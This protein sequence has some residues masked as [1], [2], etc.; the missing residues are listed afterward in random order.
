[1]TAPQSTDAPSSL[2]GR[3][4]QPAAYP[5]LDRTPF[6]AETLEL[7]RCVRDHD[8][9]TLSGLC[10]DDFGIVDLDTDGSA[11]LV[12]D[13]AAWE[14]W[15]QDLFGRLSTLGARTDT[16]VDALDGLVSGDLGYGVC[17]F[18]Q[19]LEAGGHVASFRCITTIV[20]KRVDG[21][22]VESRWHASLLEA[23]V[24]DALAAAG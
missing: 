13:R 14:E 1:M 8:L 5:E 23:D 3:R 24:P 9:A 7:F 11:R 18:T 20:W 21:R 16:R 4:L 17:Q 22:W 15:F 6:L 12:P 10:D 19:L 2:A